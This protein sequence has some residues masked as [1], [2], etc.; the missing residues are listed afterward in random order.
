MDL[1]YNFPEKD[2]EVVLF[3]CP[4][5]VYK[6]QLFFRWGGPLQGQAVDGGD[7]LLVQ[8]GKVAGIGAA[9]QGAPGHLGDAVG[10]NPQIG[11]GGGHPQGAEEGLQP[12]N[13]LQGCLLYTSQLRPPQ[14]L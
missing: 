12:A 8:A 9:V 5:D 4:R 7:V 1:Q 6:R 11:K 14:R 3:G 13:A 10:G 2:F